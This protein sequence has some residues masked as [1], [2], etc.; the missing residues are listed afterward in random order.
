VGALVALALSGA[1][2]ARAQ[3]AETQD[4]APPVVGDS[5]FPHGDLNHW[6]SGQANIIAQGHPGFHALY[7]GEQSLLPTP[8]AAVSF[9]G[10]L[11]TGFRPTPMT[12][13]IADIEMAAGNGISQVFGLGGYTN[14]DV[15]RNPTLGAEPYIAR[16]MLR[17]VFALSDTWVDVERGP[18]QLAPRLPERRLQIALGKLATPDFFDRNGAGSDSHTQFLNW[19][20]D[21]TGAY[22]YAA[23]TR[24][25][26]YGIVATYESPR[27]AARFGLMLMPKV[28]NGIQLDFN[29][30]KSRAENLEV[31]LRYHLGGAPGIAR[32]LG[33]LNHANM[34][35]YADAIAARNGDLA[36]RTAL[37]QTEMKPFPLPTPVIEC[38]RD[39]GRLKGGVAFNFEQQIV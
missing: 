23:D 15:V 10:T 5:L 13:A 14:L 31:E 32:L 17:R 37:E 26:T 2:P 6:I 22:D 21:N 19:A 16:L 12:D 39:V 33:Y 30:P 28:A 38:H 3:R 9:V 8:E 25:Y 7:T 35:S 27:F 24:G 20:I 29:I 34:G 18:L 1:R 11:F 36:C 4:A